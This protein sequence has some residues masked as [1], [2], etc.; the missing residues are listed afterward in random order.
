MGIIFAVLFGAVA[1][2]AITVD[3]PKVY[4]FTQEHLT[5]EKPAEL[6]DVNNGVEKR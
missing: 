5:G 4:E 3:Q 1:G 2:S 6:G